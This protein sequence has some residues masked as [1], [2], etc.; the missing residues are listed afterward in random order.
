MKFRQTNDHFDVDKMRDQ[1]AQFAKLKDLGWDWE[2][3]MYS[4]D[5]RGLGPDRKGLEFYQ[6]IL[7]IVLHL[8]PAGQPSLAL[9]KIVFVELEKKEQDSCLC[10]SRRIAG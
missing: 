1:L 6:E 3:S 8:S 7:D 2:F 9:L 4:K 5:R 10:K